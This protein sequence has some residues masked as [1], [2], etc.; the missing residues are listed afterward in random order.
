[1]LG[2]KCKCALAFFLAYENDVGVNLKIY[3]SIS[4]I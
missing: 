2:N 1:M 4:F 3:R